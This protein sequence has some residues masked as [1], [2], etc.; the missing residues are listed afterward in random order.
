MEAREKMQFA[1][2]LAT[3]SIAGWEHGLGESLGAIFHIHHGVSCA[4]FL[5]VG[6]AFLSKVTDRF[7]DLAKVFKIKR[8]GKQKDE[9]LKEL[10]KKLRAFMKVVGCPLSIKELK[11]PI[12][13]HE[14]YMANMDKLFQ[15]ANNSYPVLSSSRGLTEK[16]IRKL[17]EISY[18][19]KL[20]DLMELFYK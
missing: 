1:A 5:C 15:Y 17:F 6:I 14:E 4:L 19:N 13:T 10:L 16:V 3:S 11:D 2:W 7:L 9:I 20:E 18:E 12:I 8:K